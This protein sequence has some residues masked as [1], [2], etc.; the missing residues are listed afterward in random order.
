MSLR[1][2]EKQLQQWLPE[3]DCLSCSGA[4]K[5]RLSAPGSVQRLLSSLPGGRADRGRAATGL[6]VVAR[7]RS[8]QPL[9]T[10]A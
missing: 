1:E 3:S 4:L 8:N 2:E 5:Q 7:G 10:V 6:A 9:E